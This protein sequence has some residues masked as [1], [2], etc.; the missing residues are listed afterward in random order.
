MLMGV[1]VEEE[2]EEQGSFS[3]STIEV[4]LFLLAKNDPCS[5][6][7]LLHPNPSQHHCLL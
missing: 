5:S 2:K 7:Y 6:F 1:G 3:V 4:L